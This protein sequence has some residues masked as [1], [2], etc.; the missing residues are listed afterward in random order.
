MNDLEVFK[1]RIVFKNKDGW[2]RLVVLDV[3]FSEKDA[4]RVGQEKLRLKG[5]SGEVWVTTSKWN[6]WR[7]LDK[8][9]RKVR[10]E[11]TQ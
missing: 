8:Q 9:G 6:Y 4:F 1:S 5:V 10:R 3:V 11:K 7:V 2:E